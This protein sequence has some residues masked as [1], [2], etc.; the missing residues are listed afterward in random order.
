VGFWEAWESS[1]K[2][3]Q[4]GDINDDSLMKLTELM[5]GR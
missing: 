1:V 4:E 2:A 5:E 3:I